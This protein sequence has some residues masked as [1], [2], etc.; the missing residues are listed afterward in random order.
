MM[1]LGAVPRNSITT[2]G[3]ITTYGSTALDNEREKMIWTRTMLRVNIITG[4]VEYG[5]SPEEMKEVSN[6]E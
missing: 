6:D 1:C 2:N 4:A 3:R 5:P